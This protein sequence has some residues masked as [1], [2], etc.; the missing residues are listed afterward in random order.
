[1]FKLPNKKANWNA[2]TGAILGLAFAIISIGVTVLVIVGFNDSTTNAQATVVFGNGLT[3]LTNF[4]SQLGTVGTIAGVLLLVGLV[5]LV[6]M[7]AYGK[8]R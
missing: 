1:M 7:Y 3:M 8:Y 4:T 2:I 5:S 6:G